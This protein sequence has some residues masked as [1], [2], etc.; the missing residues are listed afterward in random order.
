MSYQWR[1]LV[2]A[3]LWLNATLI[4]L[5]GVPVLLPAV[6]EEFGTSTAATAWVALAYSL[7]MA[8][9]FMPASHVGDL[10]GHKRVAL[11]GSYFEVGFM[12]LILIAPN[13]AV[14]IAL[15]FAQ[16]I[17]HSLAVP[18]FN[19]F[20][21]GGF[22]QEQ[23]GR[24]A[25]TLGG[26]VGAGMMV[27]PFFV[28][29]VTDQL[30][31][32]WVFFIGALIVLLI[33][34]WGSLT[35]QERTARRRERPSLRQFD[36][37]GALLLMLAVSPFIVGVQLIRGDDTLWAWVLI[38][39]A[40][41]LMAAFIALQARLEHAT[42]P[43]RMF[44]RAV[45]AVPSIY[46]VAAQFSQGV[47]VYLMPVF[48]IQGLGWTATYA[49]TVVIAA[50]VGRPFAA[51]VGGLLSDRFG[52]A[53]VV[54]LA[55]TLMVASLAG[56]AMVGSGGGLVGLLPFMVLFGIAHSMQMSAMQKQMFGAVP[57]DALGMAPGVLGLGRH[58]GQATG[59]GIAATIFASLFGD[60]SAG[61]NVSG[62]MD[63]FRAALLATAA[64]VG[65][66]F[67]GAVIA[68]RTWGAA[69]RRTEEAAAAIEEPATG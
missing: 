37:P 2:L 60:A 41:L 43:V 11:I 58:L 63:G 18:N 13:L 68:S 32:R 10:L 39:L 42:L 67:A 61:G 45:F 21:I 51:P 25:G 20:A 54:Y 47:I 55:A 62:A 3:I 29:F 65:V 17:V 15:R 22:P 7:A 36:L 56:L 4:P 48:F 50:A 26:A 24:A 69:Q 57:R 1:A 12:L 8:G 35:F 40:V 44:K 28:G 52:S 59:V 49:G 46:N 6:A 66:T 19:A 27:V 38:A 34:I 16:G 14:L 23:R 9:A 30:G 5:I 53:P 64:V 33:T 31:W